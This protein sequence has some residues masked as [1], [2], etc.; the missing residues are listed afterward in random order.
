[1]IILTRSHPREHGYVL[2]FTLLLLAIAATAVAS[3]TRASLIRAL[4]A[5]EAT[6]DLQ[7]RW[8]EITCRT[9][10]L[11]QAK[12]ILEDDNTQADAPTSTKRTSITLGALE[13]EVIVAD[14][15]AKANVNTL[16]KRHGRHK[17]ERLIKDHLRESD[18][19]ATVRLTPYAQTSSESQSAANTL[20][21]FGS[22][23]QVFTNLSASELIEPNGDQSSV[24]NTITCWG[25]GKLHFRRTT[26]FALK[27]ACEGEVDRDTIDRFIEI[28][29]QSP[30]LNLEGVL[31]H[32]PVTQDKKDRFTEILTDTSECYSV[33]VVSRSPKRTRYSL[34]VSQSSPEDSTAVS[35]YS[36]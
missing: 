15:Q 12:A 18:L 34:T 1:M 32:L 13:F 3:V 2:V 27:L 29:N 5:K 14:E 19:S 20:P 33:W 21:V 25:D 6:Q 10:F 8:G 11:S 4:Q 30:E 26:A 36:W 22:L 35:T 23:G 16:Y 31:S 24:A 9:T 17:T 28:R 7:Q